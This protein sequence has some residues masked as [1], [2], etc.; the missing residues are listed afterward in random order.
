MQRGDARQR[1]EAAVPGCLVDEIR[2]GWVLLVPCVCIRLQ[3]CSLFRPE[4][5][6]QHARVAINQMPSKRATLQG[7]KQERIIGGVVVRRN[8]FTIAL[9]RSQCGGCVRRREAA[10]PDLRGKS[11]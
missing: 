7:S 11:G 9:N 6:G 5:P 2:N 4:F 8:A 10:P 3:L 1:G